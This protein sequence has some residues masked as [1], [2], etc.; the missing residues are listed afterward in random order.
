MTSVWLGTPLDSYAEWPILV[1]ANTHVRRVAH[2]VESDC[3][4]E[5]CGCNP[6]GIY[7]GVLVVPVHT[8]I[9]LLDGN[10]DSRFCAY[11]LRA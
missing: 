6:L 1:I 7:L 5:L 11:E 3:A 10:E 4:G 9:T 8:R 2:G